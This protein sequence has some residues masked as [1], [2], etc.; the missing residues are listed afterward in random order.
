M[1]ELPQITPYSRSYYFA[2]LLVI[3][4]VVVVAWGAWVRISGSGA[5]CGEDWPLCNGQAV[6][7]NA[8]I[9]TWIEISHR[10]STAL[11]GLLVLA[12]I[13]CSRCIFSRGH[14]A[15]LWSILVLVFTLTEALIGRQLV[16]MKLVDESTE[17]VRMLVMPLH[18]INTSFLLFCAVMAA[19][20]FRYGD[21]ARRPISSELKKLGVLAIIALLLLMTSGA[22]AALASHLFPSLSLILG[23]R[24]DLAPTAHPAL[25]LRILHP[26]LALSLL[27]IVPYFISSIKAA[28]PSQQARLWY[29]RLGYTTYTAIL[30]GTA[31]LLLLAP[32]WLKITHLVMANVLVIVASLA[33]FHTYRP[34][35]PFGPPFGSQTR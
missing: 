4:T 12:L 30:I 19:E 26:I 2:W 18:L 27:L 7:L 22:I 33:L 31:T 28:A 3:Y 35:P 9:K 29:G 16:T 23:L 15:R 24:K 32:A 5:G 21:R 6:P 34:T 17:I 14:P 13:I 8:P 20:S 10:Y 1:N 11:Y 25:R